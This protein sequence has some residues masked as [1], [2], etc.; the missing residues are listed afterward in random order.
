[1]ADI[2]RNFLYEF[3]RGLRS[4]YS[5]SSAVVSVFESIDSGALKLSP[6]EVSNAKFIEEVGKCIFIIKKIVADPYKTLEGRQELVP[7]SQAQ[8]MD[9]ESVK[10]TLSDAS[11]WATKDG[12]RTPKKAY[13]VINETA[14]K[15]Y[16]NAFVS[17]LIS[18][19]IMRLRKIKARLDF[20]FPDKSSN[21]YTKTISLIETYVHKL[22]RLSNEKVFVD[23]NRREIDMS[24]IF[25]TDVILTDNRYN[26]C[27]RFFI[28]YFKANAVNNGVGRDYRVL[29]HNFALVQILYGLYK[30]GY[31][32]E[33]VKYYISVSGKMFFDPIELKSEKEI[34][35]VQKASGVDITCN[36]KLAH[37]EFSK[38]SI[39]D[40]SMVQSGYASL[41]AKHSASGK[42]SN[43]YLAYLSSD[44]DSIDGVLNIGYKNAEK[45]IRNLINSL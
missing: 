2:K 13:S 21:E 19:I 38:S 34:I 11:V 14:F 42:Y 12:K 31:S 10:L 37:I 16:E 23:N 26:Y 1:M 29:Y 24:D 39:K 33:N 9:H 20:D 18:L 4:I 40:S 7:V 5:G 45:T 15:S 27:Y 28:E 41:E 25:L 3:N 8:N 44:E 6:T 22:T 17:K 30:A 36:N 32:F 35:V 43:V